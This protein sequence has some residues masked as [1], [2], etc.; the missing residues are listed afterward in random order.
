MAIHEAL[1]FILNNPF[2]K[3]MMHS[4]AQFNLLK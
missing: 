2:M 3:D 4:T 1:F